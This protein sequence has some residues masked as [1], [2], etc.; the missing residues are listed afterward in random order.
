MCKVGRER[1]TKFLTI[2]LFPGLVGKIL[3]FVW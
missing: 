3:T 2:K 1:R